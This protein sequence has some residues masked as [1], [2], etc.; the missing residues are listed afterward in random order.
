MLGRIAT[1]DGSTHELE[2]IFNQALNA[3]DMEVDS[4]VLDQIETIG[5]GPNFQ[6][7]LTWLL[8]STAAT[9]VVRI[10]DD[11][12]ASHGDYIIADST[13]NDIDITLPTPSIGGEIRVKK[14]VGNNAVRVNAVGS[15]EIDGQSLQTLSSQYDFL[16]LTSDGV[17]YWLN[18]STG[19]S[20][21][22][23]TW[24]ELLP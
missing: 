6:R 22:P 4:S 14:I 5:I 2:T 19:G 20:S 10:F 11:Y 23:A 16:H 13:N 12:T 17:D 24:D 3:I 15:A 9:N 7:F 21:G 8:S 18:Q 1:T